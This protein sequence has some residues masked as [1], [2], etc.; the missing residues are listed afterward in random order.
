M[1]EH[2]HSDRLGETVE[3]TTV[4][5]SQIDI[6]REEVNRLRQRQHD[7]SGI[8]QRVIGLE[9]SVNDLKKAIQP[10]QERTT[11]LE[12]KIKALEASIRESRMRILWGVGILVT[13]ITAAINIIL[14]YV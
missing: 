12:E 4:S 13:I 9:A 14:R 3:G 7:L 2:E 6:L 8:G 10:L 11:R 5:P 1:N